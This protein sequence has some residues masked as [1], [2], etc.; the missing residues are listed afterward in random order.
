MA[1]TFH[2][3]YPFA[4]FMTTPDEQRPSEDL[5]AVAAT[6]YAPEV[7]QDK[8]RAIYDTILRESAHIKAGNFTAASNADLA[9]LFELYDA[10]FFRG[11]LAHALRRHDSPLTFRLAARMTRAGGKTYRTRRRRLE[12]GT[13]RTRSEYEIAISSTLLFQSF[14]DVQRPVRINGLE[15]A[16]RLQA[17]QRIFEHELLHLTELLVWDRSSCSGKRFKALAGQFFAHTDVRHDLVTPGERALVTFDVRVGDRVTFEHEGVRHSGVVNRITR[18][19]TVLVENPSG[20]RYSDG[21]RYA[22]FY[23]PL[24]ALRKADGPPA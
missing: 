24:A 21:R 8:T 23:V 11:T 14:R 9:R 1:A 5:P 13:A 16:D 7:V 4:P 3:G 6:Q 10:S 19:A 12:N 18:R 22:K 15:C 20:Q 17:L 2:H